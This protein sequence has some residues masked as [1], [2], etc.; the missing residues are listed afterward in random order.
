MPSISRK[1][2][3]AI[4]SFTPTYSTASANNPE[5]TP[6]I[7]FGVFAI[8][9]AAAT[10]WQG[11]KL[12]RTLRQHAPPP[13]AGETNELELASIRTTPSINMADEPY[14]PPHHHAV[15]IPMLTSWIQVHPSCRR[16]QRGK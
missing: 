8:I 13:T 12:W 5:V 16:V 3:E 10:L 7:I 6:N 11:H 14:A 2:E 1:A 15:V 4:A 9:F